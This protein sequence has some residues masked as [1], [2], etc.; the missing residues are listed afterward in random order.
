MW[1]SSCCTTQNEIQTPL[2]RIHMEARQKLTIK[3]TRKAR[4]LDPSFDHHPATSRAHALPC[5]TRPFDGCSARASNKN[6]AP[7]VPVHASR[8]AWSII[9]VHGKRV[10]PKAPT[11]VLWVGGCWTA[12]SRVAGSRRRRWRLC[13][14]HSTRAAIAIR[15]GG[16][17]AA[18]WVISPCGVR[19]ARHGL[20]WRCRSLLRSPARRCLDCW[21]RGR[22]RNSPALWTTRSSQG[23]PEERLR[24]VR[25]Y[26]L[27]LPLH[28]EDGPRIA[29]R[30]RPVTR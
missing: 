22:G 28:S 24:S 3:Q 17:A 15:G 14:V 30:A 23:G 5:A 2:R 21:F 7:R 27:R 11:D 18:R 6:L 4:R 16:G 10:S 1:I 8:P 9:G 12:R 26:A 19:R 29:G 25:P 20:C 13:R